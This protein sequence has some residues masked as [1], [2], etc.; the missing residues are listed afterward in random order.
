M[1]EW[2]KA[3]T[4]GKIQLVFDS[5]LTIEIM[6]SINN[7]MLKQQRPGIP[8]ELVKDYSIELLCGGKQVFFQRVSGNYQRL[9]RIAVSPAVQADKAVIKVLE[10]NGHPSARIYEIRMY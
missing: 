9:N 3:K 4:I 5:N 2:E 8:P 10:T 7:T 1:F 6:P